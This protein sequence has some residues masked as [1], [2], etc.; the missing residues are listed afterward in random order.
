[1]TAESLMF[2]D[3][4]VAFTNLPAYLTG[5]EEIRTACDSKAYTGNQAGFTAAQNITVYVIMDNRVETAPAW[6]NTWTKQPDQ[7]VNSKDVSF[8]IYVKDFAAGETVTLGTN[9][10]SSGCVNYTV[11]VTEQQ[12]IRGDVN[13][14]GAVNLADAVTL[15]KYLLTATKTLPDWQAGDMDENGRLNAVDLTLLKRM[16]LK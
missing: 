13:A 7:V 15:Q 8:S 1:M 2:G 6:L 16:L 14:D 5:A 4:E 10:Q 3:R 12:A 9:G 11:A